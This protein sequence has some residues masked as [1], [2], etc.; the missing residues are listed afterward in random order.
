MKS[1]KPLTAEERRQMDLLLNLILEEK[2]L[3]K[4][5]ALVRALNI[6]LKGRKN[7]DIRMHLPKSA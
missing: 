6:L 2:D 4:F 7:V 5:C 1:Y 3:H